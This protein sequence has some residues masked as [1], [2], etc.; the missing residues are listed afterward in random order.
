MGGVMKNHIPRV[1]AVVLLAGFA[2]LGIVSIQHQQE[3]K[4]KYEVQIESKESQLKKLKLDYQQL[5]TNLD[6]ELEKKVKDQEKIKE[7]EEERDRLQERE[8]KLEAD[9][10]AKLRQKEQEQRQYAQAQREV[11]NTVTATQRASAASQ[12]AVNGSKQAW[13]AASVINP[14]DYPIVDWL[15]S[16]ESSWRPTA[17]NPTSTAY[18]LAQFLNSTWQGVGCVKSSEPVY[19]LNCA[20]KYVKS[21][22]GSWSGA[23]SFWQRNNWY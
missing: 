19:Q 2:I 21:R 5:N 3:I 10:Q 8:R 17:Q 11:V 23:K 7:L 13:L 18:G 9:L 1:F 16:K 20:D 22:Y 14:T 6:I 4:A 15:I 12:T